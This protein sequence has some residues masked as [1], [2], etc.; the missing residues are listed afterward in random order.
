V[1]AGGVL[2]D[3]VTGAGKSQTIRA[4]LARPAMRDAAVV[5]EEETLGEF[6]DEELGDAAMVPDAKLWR[7]RRVLGRVRAAVAGQRFVLERFH[8]TYYALMGDWA[9]VAPIDEELAARGFRLVLLTVADGALEERALHRVDRAGTPWTGEMIAA[10][11]SEAAALAAIRASQERRIEAL[12][13]TGLR[14]LRIDTTEQRWERYAEEVEEL[15][16]RP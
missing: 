11:G 7:L 14:S 8:P 3:G 13:L 9:L 16:E 12:A 15:V 5:P 10:F 4:L 2:I 6:M 1:A